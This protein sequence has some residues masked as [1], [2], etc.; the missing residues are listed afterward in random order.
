MKKVSLVVLNYNGLLHLK[1]YF[2]SVF[3]QTLIPDEIIMFDN[4]S[5]DGSREF[6]KENYTKVK[7]I[8]ED[9]YNTGT[10]AGS[11]IAFSHS[12]GDYVVFQSNDIKLERNCIKELVRILDANK[13]VGIA[14]S[15]LLNYYKD[16]K[17][18][19]HLIDNAGGIVDIFGFGMQ[20]YPGMRRETIPESGEVFFTYGGSFIIRRSLFE[21][22]GGFDKRYFTLNDD[23]DLSWRARLQGYRVMYSKKSIVYHKVSAT[24]GKLYN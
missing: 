15:V 9:S 1:E 13:D 21:K 4:L 12:S 3:K 8:T 22:I 5:K 11:N 19:E 2:D 24:L 20:K 17:T 23:I 10:A 7:I 18:G 16:Q 6:V 14:T